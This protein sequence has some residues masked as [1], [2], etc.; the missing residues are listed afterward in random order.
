MQHL[1]TVA[2]A[3]GCGVALA[4]PASAG[5]AV[6]ITSASLTPSTTQAAAHPDVTI[7]TA[8]G[9][10]GDSASGDDVK[11]V[12][13]VLPQGLLGD[14]NAAARC[15]ASDFAADACPADTKVGTTTADTTAKLVLVDTPI[16]ADGDVYNLVPAGS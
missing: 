12:T 11:S 14:P 7:T 6:S 13:A 4:A 2:C 15:S 8:F 9:G 3:L 1:R 5:A 10:L 16:T